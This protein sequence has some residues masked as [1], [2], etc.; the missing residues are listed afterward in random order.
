MRPALA[1]AL[2]VLLTA[3]TLAGFAHGERS[4]KGHLIVSLD[5]DLSPLELPRDRP[6]PIALHLEGGLWTDDGTT[7]PRIARIELGLPAAGIL[8]ARGLPLCS[9]RALRN[10][11]RSRAL[12]RCGQA[13]VG[14]GSLS[15]E[16]A[17]P[18][19]R[20]FRSTS[21]ALAFNGRILGRPAVLLHVYASDPPTALVLPFMVVQRAG[22]LPKALV[23]HPLRALGPWLRVRH[24]HLTLFRRYR[25]RGQRR[26]YLSASCPIPRRFTAGY[27]SLARSDFTLTDGR[28]IGVGIARG[29]RASSARR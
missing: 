25:Y 17:P 19:Q 18:H 4:Q 7:L 22:R 10:A 29:C 9:P 3:L 20:A 14:R 27:F 2:L 21:R 26:S 5:G 16:V 23:A 24:F 11:T 1:T 13:V 6:A 12:R 28:R 15:A 8:S